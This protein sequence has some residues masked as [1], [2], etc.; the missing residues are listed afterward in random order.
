MITSCDQKVIFG[1]KIPFQK[2]ICRSS[3]IRW[4]CHI[5]YTKP[6]PRED[7]R[8]LTQGGMIVIHV[9]VCMYELEASLDMNQI[10][11]REGRGRFPTVSFDHWPPRPPRPM[12]SLRAVLYPP[13]R[14]WS[15][16]IHLSRVSFHFYT[17]ERA[18]RCSYPVHRK[19]R[20]LIGI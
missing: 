5:D 17:P 10:R 15:A 16:H 7:V 11:L 4:K 13:Y 2:S 12:T 3:T 6:V 14:L 18:R 9:A 19:G 8:K 1:L 20:F